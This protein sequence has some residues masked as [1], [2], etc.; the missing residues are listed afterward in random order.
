MATIFI[1]VTA[2]AGAAT[3]VALGTSNTYGKGVARGQAY[4][5][6]LEAILRAEGANVCHKC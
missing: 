6:Q 3:I 4:P 2:P 5:A 1:F